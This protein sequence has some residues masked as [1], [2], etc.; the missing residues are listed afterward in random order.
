MV[1]EPATTTAFSGMMSGLSGVLAMKFPVVVSNTGVPF[2]SIV[3][4]AMTAAFLTMTP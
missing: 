4:A 3:P 1:L 2:V